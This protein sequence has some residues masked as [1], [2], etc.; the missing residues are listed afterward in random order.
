M[1][2]LAIRIPMFG[3]QRNMELRGITPISPSS[4]PRELLDLL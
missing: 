1:C 2:S 3:E 4:T